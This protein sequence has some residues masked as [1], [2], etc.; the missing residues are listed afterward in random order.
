MGEL[1]VVWGVR[2][3]GVNPLIPSRLGLAGMDLA[4]I[5][6]LLWLWRRGLRSES[7]APLACRCGYAVE[8]LVAP[9]CPECGRGVTGPRLLADRAAARRAGLAAFALFVL[10]A[11]LVSHWSLLRDLLEIN[12]VVKVGD[13]AFLPGYSLFSDWNGIDLGAVA[14]VGLLFAAIAATVVRGWRREAAAIEAR[15][16]P[17]AAAL[18]ERLRSGSVAAVGGAP[19]SPQSR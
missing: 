16:R 4:F 11:E 7:V 1:P 14:L 9:A 3:R 12:R 5:L 8:G 13:Y 2:I 15:L 18:E 17:E 19:V 10:L 6:G